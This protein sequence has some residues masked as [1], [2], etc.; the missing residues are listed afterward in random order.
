MKSTI[1][2][3]RANLYGP[4][5]NTE[6]TIEAIQDCIKH[7]IDMELDIWYKNGKFYL[8]HDEPRLEFDPFTY[9][10]EKVYVWFHCKTIETLDKLLTVQFY[11]S[12]NYSN[13][14]AVFFHDKDATTLTSENNFW[15]YPGKDLF[16]KS[17]AVMPEY[18]SKEYEKY[19]KELFLNNMIAGV[20]TDYSLEW[21]QLRK[22]K[23]I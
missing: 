4:N 12:Q 22:E 15:T 10:F 2:A 9:N 20:C 7:D 8:G 14:Y 5:P 23:I 6:N 16:K 13:Q 18:V 19:T 3:H 21:V 17:I 11:R 1:I